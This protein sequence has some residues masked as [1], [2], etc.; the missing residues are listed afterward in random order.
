MPVKGEQL[1]SFFN[2]SAEITYTQKVNMLQ[3]F[4]TVLSFRFITHS[5]VLNHQQLSTNSYFRNSENLPILDFLTESYN[6]YRQPKQSSLKVPNIR[7]LLKIS[8]HTLEDYLT[9]LVYTIQS[10]EECYLSF[11]FSCT[12]HDNGYHKH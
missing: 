5:V 11:I 2:G 1:F 12:V 3:L 6:I 8:R 10:I 4:K 9:I 7:Q